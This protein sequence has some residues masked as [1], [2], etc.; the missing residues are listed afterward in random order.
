MVL[1]LVGISM[2]R[3]TGGPSFNE[4]RYTSHEVTTPRAVG[5]S[6]RTYLLNGTIGRHMEP[7][8]HLMTGAVLARTGFNRKAAYATLAMTIAA[9]APDL[10]T[11][12]SIDGPIAAFQHHRGITHTFV[13]LPFEAA[14][15][16]GGFWLF[17]RWR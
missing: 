10:D 8:T 5:P 2:C 13:G 17:H 6:G 16:V 12:W 3:P 11:L 14:V 7:I 1:P 9:E 15:I 4:T